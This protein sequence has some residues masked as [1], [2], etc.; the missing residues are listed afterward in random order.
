MDK[1]KWNEIRR[2]A[3]EKTDKSFG[4][5]A[6]RLKKD[7]P[8]I[9]WMSDQHESATIKTGTIGQLINGIFFFSSLVIAGTT[10]NIA[11]DVLKKFPDWYENC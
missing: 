9:N 3:K 7:W 10:V 5:Q 8:Y 2:R 11:E 6:I 1:Q 4:G